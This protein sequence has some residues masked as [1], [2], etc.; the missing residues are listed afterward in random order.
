MFGF[1]I[2]IKIIKDEQ[3]HINKNKRIYS[4]KF[5]FIQ[6]ATLNGLQGR[7]RAI[8]DSHR[9]IVCVAN[10]D[11]VSSFKNPNFYTFIILDIGEVLGLNFTRRLVVVILGFYQRVQPYSR[12]GY[13]PF[14]PNSVQ[15]VHEYPPTQ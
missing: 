9:P 2:K 6:K 10:T 14:L 8:V 4:A 5:E 3:K 13:I 11:V 1:K 12:T 15:I 7:M